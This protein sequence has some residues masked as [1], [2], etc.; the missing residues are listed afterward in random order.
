MAE[1]RPFKAMKPKEDV[2]HQVASVPYD[3]VNREEAKELASGNHLSFLRVTR[4]EIELDAKITPYS[5][6][7]YHRARENWERLQR[8]APMLRDD[9]PYFYIYK[10]CWNEEEQVGIAAT[11]SIDEY[12]KDVIKKHEK[13]RPAKEDDR[14]NHILATEAHTG[15]VMLTYRGVS[16]LNDTVDNIMGENKPLYNFTAEDG[17]R[18]TIWQVPEELN[19]TIISEMEK[20][21]HLYIADGHHRAASASRAR[22]E[23]KEQ[24][25]QHNGDE[26]YNYFL[27]VLFPAEQVNILPYNRIIFR[28]PEDTQE[29]FVER[30]RENFTVEETDLQAPP[31]QKTFCMYY[32]GQWY[33]LR[34]N[35]NVCPGESVGDNLDV[36][37]LQDYLL[38]PVFGIEDQRTD[39]NIDF[40]GGI[41]GTGELE[42]LVDTGQA[43]VAF[44][45]NPVSVDDLINISDAGEIMPPKST[46]FEPKLR[47]GLLVHTI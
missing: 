4:A 34:P 8:E 9:N 1:I 46:W 37:I 45:L 41:R 42:K 24:N 10:L 44:S 13:T 14:T 11:F 38:N 26:D 6:R 39:E 16:V 32:D 19:N 21:E 22:E 27:G 7:V 33:F 28:F 23:K 18:H 43:V 30:I 40:I 2:A 20:V 47:D 36:S 29:N 31:E 5:D 35:D 15:A 3:V 12:Q 25:S 17:I